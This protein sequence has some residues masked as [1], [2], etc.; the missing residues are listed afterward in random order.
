MPSAWQSVTSQSV[1]CFFPGVLHMAESG[2]AWPVLIL[3]VPLHTLHSGQ[4]T[5]TYQGMQDLTASPPSYILS[6]VHC[7]C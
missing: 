2:P 4:E 1:I 5:H 6:I 7:K 3:P